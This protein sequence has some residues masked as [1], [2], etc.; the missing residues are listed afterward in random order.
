VEK[1]HGQEPAKTEEELEQDNAPPK[2]E[3]ER[4][5]RER[6]STPENL[7]RIHIDGVELE[8][9]EKQVVYEDMENVKPDGEMK[10]ETN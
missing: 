1:D 7:V 6:Q 5:R 2:S 3:S 9:D 4:V 10:S 8:S